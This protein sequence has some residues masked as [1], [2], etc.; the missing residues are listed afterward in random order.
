MSSSKVCISFVRISVSLAAWEYEAMTK[1]KKI[2]SCDKFI[3]F[4][5]IDMKIN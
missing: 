3:N 4:I 1:R 5:N 2:I